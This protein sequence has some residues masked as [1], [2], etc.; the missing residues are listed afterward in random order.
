MIGL[1]LKEGKL[2]KYPW[3]VFVIPAVF[4]LIVGA[5]CSAASPTS[6]DTSSIATPATV[7]SG[8][9]NEPTETVA[10][11]VAETGGPAGFNASLLSPDIVQLN[12]EAVTGAAGYE[13]QRVVRSG[14]NVPIA[15]LSADATSFVDLMSPE[16]STLTY[17]LQTIKADGPAGASS[18]Q[19]TTRPRQPNPLTVKAS[20]TDTGA[21]KQ[22]IGPEG[23][24]LKLTDAKGVNYT[25][26]VPPGALD[27]ELE[28]TMT[29]IASIDSWPLDGKML[30]GVRL[31]PEGFQLNEVASLTFDASTKL[32]PK[33]GMV[34]YSFEGGGEEFHLQPIYPDPA[35]IA[36]L[37]TAGAHLAMP[38]AQDSPGFSL[39]IVV[40]GS[41][42]AG[43]SSAESAADMA[44][45][46]APTSSEAA[47]RQKAAAASADDLTP[48]PVSQIAS[49]DILG[50]ILNAGNCDDFKSAADAFQHWDAR[51]SKVAAN[52]DYE[53][54]D[55]TR[56]TMMEQLAEKAVETIEKAG[57]EC[58][59]APKGNVPASVPC[60]EKMLRNIESGST[61]FFK[62][63]QTQI[64]KDSGLK[65]RLSNSHFDLNKCPHSYHA[66]DAASLGRSWVKQCIPT[67][68]RS[69]LI[70][71][72]S[73]EGTGEFGFY[74][75]DWQSGWAKF[76]TKTTTGGVEI[77]QV[78]QGPY[79]VEIIR[80][81]NLGNPVEMS[82]NIEA[83][84]IITQCAAGNCT[85]S[86]DVPMSDSVPVII[87]DTSCK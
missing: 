15:S 43:Q 27:Y 16:S 86:E 81:D 39:P 49:T 66:N 34:G 63:L 70:S 55:G 72:K 41:T 83:N 26:T 5:A 57:D 68:D 45:N 24:T 6:T 1:S 53:G 19:I 13:V 73:P 28:I 75:D 85:T 21:V 33:L 56:A 17:R 74:P 50:Q 59:K 78:G 47:A 32:N 35:G 48:L 23:G 36:G 38:A 51:A 67:M 22:I 20:F 79:T 40:L 3:I 44:V 2:S 4:I 14:E 76:K 82:L 31:E 64:T 46:H 25:F 9:V 30:G 69:Y 84:G 77:T 54:Y 58:K 37:Q 42:G 52:G 18:L 71:W 11:F 80:K 7:T 62:E 8:S 29:P 65:D 87:A 61:P 60:A 12:W 10:P